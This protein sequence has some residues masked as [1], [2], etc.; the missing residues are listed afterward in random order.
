MQLTDVFVV[1]DHFLPFYPPK[2]PKKSKFWKIQKKRPGDIII[3]HVYHKWQS[4]D[5]WF[6][7]YEVQQTEFLS[8]WTIFCHF[9]PLKTQKIKILKKVEKMPGT[10]VAK[11]MITGCMVP[12]IW[13]AMDRRID[14][15][16][17]KV[18]CG[19]GCPN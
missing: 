19:E 2:Q 3:L 6:L 13:Y 9:T 15:Q 8:F 14:G 10:C 16:T 5:L 1:L 7:R 12:K 18:T 11:M 17:G 4:Y